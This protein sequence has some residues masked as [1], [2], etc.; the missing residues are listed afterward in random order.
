MNCGHLGNRP[1]AANECQASVQW[2]ALFL[3]EVS[4]HHARGAALAHDAV[5]EDAIAAG[6]GNVALALTLT[7]SCTLVIVIICGP[8]V[9]LV[10]RAH[11]SAAAAVNEVKARLE[12]GLQLHVD[13]VENG[14]TLVLKGGL[15]VV[16]DAKLALVLLRRA[17]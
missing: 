7:P 15:E 1:D 10:A 9:A 16:V 8:H 5:H 13:F 6:A 12:V 11:V 17:V 3:H 2:P 4:D 14:D